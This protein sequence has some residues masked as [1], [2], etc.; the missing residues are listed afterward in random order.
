M[1][2]LSYGNN[3]YEHLDQIRERPAMW[4]GNVSVSKLDTYIL[5]YNACC[6]IK[7]IEEN[8]FPSWNI[9]HEFVK[10]KTNF[11]ESTSGWCNMILTHC[12]G[13][14]EK[15]FAVFYEYFDEFK[16]GETLA[17][18]IKTLVPKHKSDWNF[19]KSTDFLWYG[20]QELK[21]IIPQLLEWL[22]DYNFPVAKPIAQ[23]LQKML[24]DIIPDLIPILNGQD[25]VWKYWILQIFFI[26]TKSEYWKKIDKIIKRLAL[27]PTDIERKEEV[28]IL[29]LEILNDYYGSESEMSNL[30]SNWVGFANKYAR[31]ESYIY[32]WQNDMDARRLIDE[33][34]IK[35]DENQKVGL[36]EKLQALDELV[37]QKTFEVSECIWGE[38]NEKKYGWNREKQW[39]YYRVNQLV[40]DNEK[41]Y[42][43]RNQNQL[44]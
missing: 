23:H 26:E 36:L 15:A 39:Y 20:Y 43:T 14:E 35:L 5:G 19:D 1:Q 38:E 44:L 6:H 25:A 18:F 12:A 10:R 4:I 8:L 3:L 42:F 13:D 11:S 16:K 30:I 24:P 21:P 34:L 27:N 7:G 22:Q 32:E 2:I 17:T 40:F 28:D 31:E 9:F 37:I 41:G 33:K 29:A